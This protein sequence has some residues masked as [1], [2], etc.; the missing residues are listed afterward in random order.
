MISHE[1]MFHIFQPVVSESRLVALIFMVSSRGIVFLWLKQARSHCVEYYVHLVLP[2]KAELKIGLRRRKKKRFIPDE[3]SLIL[4]GQ[5]M[6][7]QDCS[8]GEETGNCQA[9][10][11]D[12]GKWGIAI[13]DNKTSLYIRWVDKLFIKGQ[14]DA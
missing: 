3:I 9:R 8:C 7:S 13:V 10:M 4:L 2:Q 5:H 12:F 11:Q 14:M 1:V 6:R